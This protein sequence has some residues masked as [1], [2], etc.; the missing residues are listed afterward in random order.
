MSFD[1][2]E[3]KMYCGKK[4]KDLNRL[5]MEEFDT[6]SPN[7]HANANV[8]QLKQIILPA[9]F[10]GSAYMLTQHFKQGM[11]REETETPSLFS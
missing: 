5:Q 2:I 9:I 11:I 8:K 6:R 4:T 1:E 10:F 7:V 3:K